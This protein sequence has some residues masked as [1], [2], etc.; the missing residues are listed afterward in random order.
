MNAAE[1]GCSCVFDHSDV[2]PVTAIYHNP[3]N[4]HAQLEATLRDLAE[5]RLRH[6]KMW[7]TNDRLCARVKDLEG[8]LRECH[9]AAVELLGTSNSWPEGKLTDKFER[10]LRRFID[11]TPKP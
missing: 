8:A 11:L 6:V 4:I 7:E 10:A 3:S 5:V 2:G 9:E 1:C